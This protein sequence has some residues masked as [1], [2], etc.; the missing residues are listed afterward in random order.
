M[1]NTK[2]LY[3][4]TPFTLLDYPNKTAC[5]FWF[6][7][8]NMRCLYCYNPEIVL[9]K[10]KITI[11]T[12]I[13]FIKKRKGLLDAV[14]LSGGESTLNNEIVD[15]VKQIKSN[16]LLVKIDTNGS[17]PDLIE[18]LIKNR[19]VD[20]IAL[21]IKCLNEDY[22]KITKFKLKD[23]INRTIKTLISSNIDYEVRT[24]YHS[25]LLNKEHIYTIADYLVG[26]GYHKEYY[27]QNFVNEKPT[28]QTIKQDSIKITQ[29]EI[30]YKKL[31]IV[32]RN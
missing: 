19:L 22:P 21:D 25:I 11:E 14:V 23:Q 18:S 12:A 31:K 13:N 3:N 5:I 16:G 7:G 1:S 29:E 28:L 32:I 8:C 9:N 20:Y 6:A 10:G 4:I 27:I 15:I 30:H 2:P 17:K 24:T 26:L